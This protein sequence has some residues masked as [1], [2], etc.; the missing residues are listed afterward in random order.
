MIERAFIAG[1]L[2]VA[3]IAP[4]FGA[5]VSV[6]TGPFSY[7]A[8]VVNQTINLQQFDSTLGTLQQVDLT[9]TGNLT[10]TLATNP[11]GANPYDVVWSKNPAPAGLYPPGDPNSTWG[12]RFLI[13]DGSSLGLDIGN[14]VV[15]SGFIANASG[16]TGP[17]SFT[18][19]IDD[20]RSYSLTSNLGAFAGPGLFAF[21][22]NANTYDT[23]GVS[24]STPYSLGSAL[25]GNLTATYTYAPA[26]VPVPAA[27]PLLVSGLGMFG[28]MKRRR[29]QKEVAAA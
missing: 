7:L 24:G 27:L 18:F 9:L 5:T 14:Q 10:S 12:F 28:L 4:T 19:A 17:R 23:V 11:G 16:L 8:D 21:I 13:A 26:Q 25:T 29:K 3:S 20:S 22:A 2:A 15:S 6:T 1:L